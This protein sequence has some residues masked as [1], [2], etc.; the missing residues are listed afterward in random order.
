MDEISG[1]ILLIIYGIYVFTT[2]N[3][4]S[5]PGLYISLFVFVFYL[6]Y[7][8]FVSYNTYTAIIL[9]FLIQIRP[10]LT[11]FIV[12]QISPSFSESQKS[13]LKRL[14]FFMWLFFIPIGIY[15]LVNSTF[16]YSV[17][18]HPSNYVVNICSLSLV[19]LF[20]SNF[21]IRERF[22]FL[23]MFSTG[24]L[25]TSTIFYTIFLLTCGI[26]LYFNH[27]DIFKFNLRTSIAIGV[28]TLIIVHIIRVQIAT[29]LLPV[30]NLS[31][32][33]DLP[34]RSVL[35]QT[36]INI[37]S[38]DFVPL[39]SGLASFGTDASGLYY[40]EIYSRYGLNS[41]D[42]L[43]PQNWYS[44]SDSYYPSLAQFGIIGIILYLFFWG[45]IIYKSF[46]K[47]RQNNDIQLFAITLILISFVFIENLSDSFLTSNKGYYM[48]MFLG[49]LFGK[50]KRFFY[51]HENSKKME[52]LPIKAD[53]PGD[54]LVVQKKH[55]D[56]CAHPEKKEIYQMPPI[57]VKENDS[58]ENDKDSIGYASHSPEI[59]EI[60]DNNYYDEDEDYYF[61]DNDDFD[62]TENELTGKLLASDSE[63]IDNK[64]T[65]KSQEKLSGNVESSN[66]SQSYDPL[67]N[68]ESEIDLLS[69]LQNDI[70]TIEND[71]ANKTDGIIT[72]SDQEVPNTTDSDFHD[73][74]I[75]IYDS[76]IPDQANI[77]DP[78][79][80]LTKDKEDIHSEELLT[81]I[82]LI[83][84]NDE[85]LQNSLS[86]IQNANEIESTIYAV[87]PDD[88][89]HKTEETTN[90]SDQEISNVAEPTLTNNI[91]LE[92]SIT[93]NDIP[94]S[95]NPDTGLSV[96]SEEETNE[97]SISDITS[98]DNN[99][100]K[101]DL[102]EE[103]EI[104][105]SDN[106]E[107]NILNQ[108]SKPKKNI[109]INENSSINK[110]STDFPSEINATESS[111]DNL[112]K[113]EIDN[114]NTTN[115]NFEDNIFTHQTQLGFI[116]PESD[117]VKEYREIVEENTT[118]KE[119][120]N[121]QEINETSDY[122][123]YLEDYLMP[124]KQENIY[125]LNSKDKNDESDEQIDYMI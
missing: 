75:P 13:L 112:S 1:F 118:K 90:I 31:A 67:V 48:M 110:S 14:C 95:N 61:D 50:K 6:C 81:H 9:D 53:L 76:L 83:E 122:L 26:L 116:K 72:I 60:E 93:D 7:S 115:I 82:P 123:K 121:I 15:G 111:T 8:I 18:G 25:A 46:V 36:A 99:E 79:T 55:K 91:P 109:L 17:F 57:P 85:E 63:T 32:E 59:K 24:L 20:C 102:T 12:A 62:E 77:T 35:Y 47:F 39:G 10:Y 94:D 64:G 68:E 88:T 92:K 107:N 70:N 2:K 33:Y 103:P 27:S 71:V 49:V 124:T 21:S 105:I 125:T 29:Y 40:S 54:N 74:I 97:Q 38:K 117:L 114:S 41:I 11:F 42:G 113:S 120:N 52:I 66:R 86:S 23:I 89:E 4:K 78:N 73:N 5:N 108:E 19:Y 101:S 34:A 69:S 37:V 45:G 65:K 58:L 51:T 84:D 22:L 104:M 87:M 43:T 56:E 28:I 98:N 44:V 119:E 3:K 100:I 96:N 80:E 106:M 30:N 16:L